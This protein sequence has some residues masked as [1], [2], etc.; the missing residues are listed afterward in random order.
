[1]KL[2]ITGSQGFIGKQLIQ[3]LL[4]LGHEI[5]GL[6]L[7]KNSIDHERYLHIQGNIL[8]SSL[9][10]NSISTGV[11]AIIHL[12]AEHKDYDIADAE[13]FSVNEQGTQN[14]L[15]CAD[16]FA[17]NN[18]IFF[19]SVAIYGLINGA[20]ETN[21]PSPS[22]PYGKSKLAA[23]TAI[24]SWIA[25]NPNRSVRIIRPAVVF[26]PDNFANIFSLISRVCDERF[27]WIGNGE[28]IKSIAY[29]ENVVAATIFLLSSLKP[30][31]EIFNY[32]DQPQLSIK[33]LVDT[34]AKFASVKVPN[35]RI[36]SK[37]A[38]SIAGLI[39]TF[40]KIFRLNFTFSKERF[41]KFSANSN[42]PSDKI[43]AAG[44]HQ[45]ISLSEGINKTVDWYLEAKQ[46][47]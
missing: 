30:G 3:S 27:L 18:F 32:S 21:L 34:V 8:D 6:D 38:F 23:E 24:K 36:P 44:Y 7:L 14:L 17:I 28:N 31:F 10:S 46:H 29:V 35:I 33:E 47:Q 1:M 20:T 26:G 43:R 9:L 25:N 22:T 41:K 42:Y 4:D 40:G 15:K 2:F 5:I 12:A 45:E 37:V 13:Y 16:D 19:S 39:D 11:D